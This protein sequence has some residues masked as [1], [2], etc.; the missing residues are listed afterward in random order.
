MS[1]L[2][3]LDVIFYGMKKA[4]ETILFKAPVGYTVISLLYVLHVLKNPEMINI[5]GA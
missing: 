2:L 4:P 5:S 1:Y 3:D